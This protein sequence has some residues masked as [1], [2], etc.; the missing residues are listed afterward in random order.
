MCG[1]RYVASVL[2]EGRVGYVEGGGVP[3]KGGA[4]SDSE[5][6][7]SGARVWGGVPHGRPAVIEPCASLGEA[8]PRAQVWKFKGHLGERWMGS[9]PTEATSSGN[10][11]AC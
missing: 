3:K 1:R 8:L 7:P 5:A 4:G 6:C 9:L 10:V 11:I 2:G